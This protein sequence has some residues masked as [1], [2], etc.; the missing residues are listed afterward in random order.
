MKLNGNTCFIFNKKYEHAKLAQW[1]TGGRDI[2]TY[3][4]AIHADKVWLL[5]LEETAQSLDTIT[6]RM[7]SMR[8]I[9]WPSGAVEMDRQVSTMVSITMTSFGDSIR[10]EITT[11]FI[12]E[13]ILLLKFSSGGRN[14]GHNNGSD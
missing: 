7:Q 13:S 12:T 1:G 3:E 11:T 6:S 5:V 10:K 9:V 8:D 14:G 2:G 4:Q